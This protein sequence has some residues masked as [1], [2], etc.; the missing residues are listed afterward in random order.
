MKSRPKDLI[1]P[2]IVGGVGQV[3]GGFYNELSYALAAEFSL[4]D[5]PSRSS[6]GFTRVVVILE[7]V[8]LLFQF[9]V[10]GEKYRF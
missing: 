4:I 2:A 10:V 9:R 8:Q 1:L 6:D 3:K 7:S 5:L